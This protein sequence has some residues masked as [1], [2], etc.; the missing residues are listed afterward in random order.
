MYA[1]LYKI[2]IL[3]GQNENIKARMYLATMEVRK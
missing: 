1:R 2:Y 3:K